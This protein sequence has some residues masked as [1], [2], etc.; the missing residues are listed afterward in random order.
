MSRIGPQERKV[1]AYV[2]KTPHAAVREL[3]K[4]RGDSVEIKE[5]LNAYKEP[6]MMAKVVRKQRAT[7]F[8]S[9]NDPEHLVLGRIYD[10]EVLEMIKFRIVS[11]KSSKEFEA[12]SPELNMKYYVLLQGIEDKRMENFILDFLAQRSHEVDLKGIR[13]GWIVNSSSSNDYILKY[14]RVLLDNTVEDI[15]PFFELKLESKYYCDDEVYSKAFDKAP[16]KKDKNVSKNAF[17]DTMGKLHIDR[18]DLRNVNL[19]K[20]RGYRGR[21]NAN[22]SN[23]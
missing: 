1:V 15:G 21:T 8:V 22:D 18:Q 17:K 9:N 16:K 3:V 10:G 12:L 14:V 20:S 13:Y 5:Q 4:L 23:L 11:I 19:R 6:E 2:T 7:L